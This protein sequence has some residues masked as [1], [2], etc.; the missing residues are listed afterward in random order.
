MSTCGDIWSND[1]SPGGVAA[2]RGTPDWST[3]PPG[4][5]TGGAVPGRTDSSTIRRRSIPAF[6]S[7]SLLA[8][9]P[10]LIAA[11]EERL[12]REKGINLGGEPLADVGA[13]AEVDRLDRALAV[14]QDERGEGLD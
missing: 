11:L 13:E 3:E 1:R 7:T 10:G 5:G 4:P 2:D 9:F 12:S 14:E 8:G 6:R